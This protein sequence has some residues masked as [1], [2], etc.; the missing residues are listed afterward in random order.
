MYRI[1]I[2]EDIDIERKIIRE[3]IDR[4]FQNA[5]LRYLV[6][7]YSSG[8]TLLAE[9]QDG[10]AVFDLIFMDIGLGGMNG[11]DTSIQI[12]K[13]D[14]FVNIA[15]LTSSRDYAIDGYEVGA[16]AYM[17][18]PVEDEKFITLL[19]R[20]TRTEK[21]KSLTL[22]MRGRRKDF[23]YR[24][25]VYIESRGHRIILHLS[26]GTEESA[27]YKLDEIET[28]LTDDVF[29][30]THKSYLVNMD[31][32]RNAEEDFEMITGAVVP[33]RR[34]GKKEIINRYLYYSLRKH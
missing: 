27:Y 8:E 14:Q 18:K 1:A 31:F 22:K 10:A 15:F 12:R 23:D 28:M 7:E 33:I 21:P 26:D 20:L 4:F 2:C 9:Y 24:D 29:I 13:M 32:I 3:K 6:K 30:R 11:I 5:N 17:I 19:S 25:I 34:H 16:I